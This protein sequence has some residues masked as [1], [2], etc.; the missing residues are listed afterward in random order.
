MNRGYTVEVSKLYAM[1]KKFV[2]R[3]FNAIVCARRAELR[4]AN[5]YVD[6][7]KR[8]PSITATTTI[9]D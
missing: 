8:A 9:T 6:P 3:N 1:P 2:D 4:N 7:P 5:K